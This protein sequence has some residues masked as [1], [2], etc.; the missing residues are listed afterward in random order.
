MSDSPWVEFYASD[1]LAGTAGLEVD[2]I[3]VYVTLV[4]LMYERDGAVKRDSRRLSRLCGCTPKRFEKALAGLIDQGKI[5]EVDGELF[6]K[7][8]QKEIKKRAKKSHQAKQSADARWKKKSEKIEQKQGVGDA[9]ALR[10]HT[11]RI[12][13]EVCPEDANQNQNQNQN[14]PVGAGD[15]ASEDF[16]K[17]LFDRGVSFLCAHGSSEQSAR[18]MIGKWRKGCD[19]RE[20]FDSFAE[21][22]KQG[23]TDPKAW[24]AA[25]LISKQ[26]QKNVIPMSEVFSGINADGSVK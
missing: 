3:G 6:N 15:P 26:N 25:R 1:W 10:T 21:A 14:I 22:A 7:R 16:S 24:I 23:V 18:A 13:G 17:V 20:I 9:S 5:F 2:E 11:E 19:D 12:C 4:A 8:A